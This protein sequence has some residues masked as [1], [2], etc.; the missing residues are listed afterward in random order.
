M[1]LYNTSKGQLIA[2]WIFGFFL[3]MWSFVEAFDYD[4]EFFTFL[5]FTIPF[6]LI[7]YTIGWGKERK[8]HESSK[9][10]L[11]GFLVRNKKRILSICALLILL[12][13]VGIV[14]LFVEYRRLSEEEIMEYIP[15][16]Y[17]MYEYYYEDIDFDGDDEVILLFEE[18]D[19]YNSNVTKETEGFTTLPLQ[20]MI[21]NYD[22][23]WDYA[24]RYSDRYVDIG[25]SGSSNVLYKPYFNNDLPYRIFDVGDEKLLGVFHLTWYFD[26]LSYTVDFYRYDDDTGLSKV[27]VGDYYSSDEIIKN[28]DYLYFTTCNPFIENDVMDISRLKVADNFTGYI[29]TSYIELPC[30]DYF[31]ISDHE[32][33]WFGERDKQVA[34]LRSLLDEYGLFEYGF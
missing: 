31:E 1:K 32:G 29:L 16:N 13:A 12:V 25:Y 18:S 14:S 10:N 6:L 34:G 33:W 15:S 22:G 23:G 7:F 4:S 9:S 8:K 5:F 2:I 11:K 3:W 24:G 17:Q 20:I 30:S 28:G 26:G 27:E 19:S 21:L